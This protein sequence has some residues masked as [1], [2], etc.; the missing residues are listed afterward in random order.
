MIKLHIHKIAKIFK[1][2]L[3]TLSAINYMEEGEY[4]Y[5]TY[6]TLIGPTSFEND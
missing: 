3:I 4:S 2:Q 1:I 5:V 6:E